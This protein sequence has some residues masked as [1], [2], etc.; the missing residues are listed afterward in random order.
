MGYGA[1]GQGVKVL[2]FGASGII[3]QHLRL[4]T[5]DWGQPV[6]YRQKAD[7]I[8]KGADLTVGSTLKDILESERPDV[9]VN[10][11]GESNTDAVQVLAMMPAYNHTIGINISLPK[12]LGMG[13]EKY[14]YHLVHVSTQGVFGGDQPPYK[15][16]SPCNPVNKYG[17]YKSMAE[18]FVLEHARTTIVRPTFVLGVRPLP[19]VGRANPVEQMS[20]GQRKQVSDRKFSTL[21]ARDAA[22]MLWAIIALDLG[23]ERIIHLGNPVTKTRYSIAAALGCQPEAVSHDDFPGIAQ[24]PLDTTYAEGATRWLTPWS[25]G[26]WQL[27]RDWESRKQMDIEDRAREIALFLGITEAA[28]I[29]RLSRGFGWQ[30]KEVNDEFR[31]ANPIGNDALLDWYRKTE[32]YIWELSAYHAERGFN[33]SGNV[34]GIVQRLK[35]AGNGKRVLCLGDG[36]GDLTLA[37]HEAGF[38]PVY[39]D[40]AGSR[41]AE[42]AKFHFWRRTGLEMNTLMTEGWDPRVIGSEEKFDAVVTLDFLEHCVNVQQWVEAIKGALAPG[43][44]LISQNAFAIGSGPE[45]SIPMH[46]QVND[47]YERDWDPMLAGMGFSQLGSNW[48]SRPA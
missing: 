34:S 18:R 20:S 23:K 21:F 3:S 17:E 26:I 25:E 42:F 13:T 7:P 6:W 40:L 29:D 19:H 1:G 37:L 14:G 46:L 47:R 30:H 12:A 5:P 10:L 35:D 22:R 24:R 27:K 44:L 38:Q 2:I 41:T 39:H 4:C 45:G 31:R 15:P 9:V 8:N 36:I 28:A 32:Q 48:Y 33:Y 11:A 16:E 43:G